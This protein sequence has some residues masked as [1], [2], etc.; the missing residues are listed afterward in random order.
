MPGEHRGLAYPN[1][2]FDSND[3]TAEERAETVRWYELAHGYGSDTRLCQFVPWQID[4][5][6]AAFKRYRATVPTMAPVIPRGIFS[7]HIYVITQWQQGLQY[8]IIMARNVGWAK[9][10][11]IELLNF[12][13]VLAGPPGM[14]AIADSLSPFLAG[15]EDEREQGEIAW[16]KNW[17]VDPDVL[18]SGLPLLGVA[19]DFPADEVEA[20]ASWHKKSFGDEP[21]F[22]REWA[23]LVG[24]Q[25]KAL[26]A[27]FEMSAG[28]TLAAQV[29]PLMLMHA[30]AY[31]ERPKG[32]LRGMRWARNLGVTREQ[33]VEVLNLAFFWGME[34]KM[35]EVLTDEV[36][37]E[38]KSWED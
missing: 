27:R 16:P 12:A 20:V 24:A 19:T 28:Q 5:N 14:N 35:A 33:V 11:V 18:K 23:G 4:N 31:F 1:L 36:L 17:F 30:S 7:M 8:E 38:L 21:R 34:W 22:V 25:Y 2:D 10:Q 6:P 29:Y 9:K 3:W 32:V 37:D 13:T 26:R 15:W